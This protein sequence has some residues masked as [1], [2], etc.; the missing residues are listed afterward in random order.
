MRQ[1]LLSSIKKSS[2]LL[3]SM[4]LGGAVVVGSFFALSRLWPQVD[5]PEEPIATVAPSAPESRVLAQSFQPATVRRPIFEGLVRSGTPLEQQQA[6]YV[7]AADAVRQGNGKDALQWLDDLETRYAVLAPN[8]LALRAQ[9][10]ALNQQDDL[11]NPLWQAILKQFP[12]SAAAGEAYF[13]LNKSD[14]RYGDRAIADL[15]AHPR[16]VEI[17]LARLKKSPNDRALLLLVAQYGLHLKDYKTY[18]DRLTQKFAPQLT[19]QDWQTVAFGY[20]E[21]QKY[22]EAGLAYSRAPAT[23]RNAYRA[24]RGLQLGGEKNAAIAAYQRAIAA[25]PEAPETPK[26]L[27]RLADLSEERPA[28]AALDRAIALAQRL[29]RPEDLADALARKANRLAKIDATVQAA[30]EAQLLEQ[31]SQSEAA[32]TLRWKRAWTAAQGQQLDSATEWATAIARSNPNSELAPKAL[33]WAGKWA[34]RLGK[35]QQRQQFFAQLWQRHPESY[36]TWRAAGLSGLPV[37]DFQSIHGQPVPLQ[38]PTSRLPLSAG[39]AALRELYALGEGKTA[40]ETWQLEFQNRQTPSIA[41]QLTDG[42]VRL[43]VGE[44]LD[45]LFML[46]NLRDR[47]L[48]EPEQQSQL[49]VLQSLRQDPRYWQALY[50]MPYWSD[51]QRWAQNHAVNPVLSLALM[52]Q[53]SRFEPTIQ[54]VAGAMGLMQLMPETAAEV[55]SQLK[56]ETYRL[57]DPSD[58]IRLGTWYLNST[59]QT[60]QG[61]SM[62]AIAS[63]NAGPGSVAKWL[64]T[65]DTRDADIFVETIPFDETQGYVKSVLE[66]YWNYARLYN[67]QFAKALGSRTP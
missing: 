63:Y 64:Q 57:E 1:S 46:G 4:G 54:S 32:A 62:L 10:H 12:Q 40:W 6:R 18:L 17:A 37:G 35:T 14:P 2:P 9:A 66:N 26:A 34:D 50:P 39:S 33:F 23:S 58:N 51:I 52:R 16:T 20:W 27:I 65:L 53:E 11:A 48:T 19:A 22:K 3:L 15:P 45:G 59:H 56:L 36:Y 38:T 47:V 49:A 30:V 31:S 13:N 29:K 25:F 55:A 7:L 8:I 21:K 41:E 5:A 43:E 61:N 60:Y 24:A 67:T 42:L 28:I 44:Y